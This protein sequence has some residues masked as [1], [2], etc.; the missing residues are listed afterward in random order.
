MNTPD[1]LE[2]LQA[3]LTGSEEPLTPARVEQTIQRARQT[4]GGDTVYVRAFRQQSI[5]RRTMQRRRT[6]Q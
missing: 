6:R 4:Y 5:T 3:A 1:I 2:Y